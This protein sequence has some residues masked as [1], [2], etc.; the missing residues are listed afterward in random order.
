M[1]PPA[2][3]DPAARKLQNQS[4]LFLPGALLPAIFAA[5]LILEFGV[6]IPYW[7]EWDVIAPLF[8]KISQDRISLSDFFAQAVESRMLFPRLILVPLAYLTDWNIRCEMGVSFLLA[9]IVSICIYQIGRK[10]LGP[11]CR[12]T[13]LLFMASNML[14]FS[15]I[16]H[17][18]WLT[19]HQIVAFLPAACVALA[20][21]TAYSGIPTPA[22]FAAC[23]LF[24]T[25][26]TFSLINGI[27]SWIVI[28]PVLLVTERASGKS[29][30]DL[31]RIALGWGVCC[32]VNLALYFQNYAARGTPAHSSLVD[33]VRSPLTGLRFF[34]EYVGLP[35]CIG[36]MNVAAV[37]GFAVLCLWGLLLH[38][39]LTLQNGRA[40]ALRATVGW[41]AF[42]LYG[43]LSGLG[44]TLARGGSAFGDPSFRYVTFSIY[45]MISTIHLAAFVILR[46]PDIGP[47]T[48]PPNRRLFHGL[49]AL[50]LMG[51]VAVTFG[52]DEFRHSPEFPHTAF[53]ACLMLLVSYVTAFF[54]KEAWADDLGSKISGSRLFHSFAVVLLFLYAQT[55]AVGI[56]GM[57]D[58][59]HGRLRGKACL[60]FINVAPAVDCLAQYVH[61]GMDSRKSLANFISQEGFLR[62][63]LLEHDRI[64]ALAD[65]TRICSNCGVF[66]ELNHTAG[67]RLV[68]SGWAIL[69]HRRESADLTILTHRDTDGAGR[70]FRVASILVIR[71]DISQLHRNAAYRFSG[72]EQSFGRND[73]PGPPDG[74]DA[75]AFDAINSRAYLLPRGSQHQ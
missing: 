49:V 63:K 64:L 71:D 23:A 31:A 15:P 37:V 13:A 28:L 56:D 19:G 60:S 61:P 29:G 21:R 48:P 54:P 50:V 17:Y 33:F 34:L 62:P 22:K 55:F 2:H 59:R 12:G 26:S 3:A 38:R 46:S 6:D 75:W 11:A 35:L 36:D 74:I 9:C 18:N 67:E 53:M 45:L 39:I 65:T 42:G 72:W 14:L 25:I 40:E 68:A 66:E 52:G 27:L 57:A 41:A 30:R 69:P 8:Q 16:Q 1:I 5:V 4:W 47:T 44:I 20:I 43:F 7:D 10:T 73:A 24:S 51:A 32:L 70:I 58:T